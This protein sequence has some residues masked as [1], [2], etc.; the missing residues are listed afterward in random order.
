[1]NQFDYCESCGVC[2]WIRI[3]RGHIRDASSRSLE[4]LSNVV[5]EHRTDCEV[6]WLNE[7]NFLTDQ[8]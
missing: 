1:M 2:K 3:Y 7:G 8:E 6:Q 5:I 4:K